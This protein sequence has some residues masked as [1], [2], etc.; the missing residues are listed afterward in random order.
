[1]VLR[2]VARNALDPRLLPEMAR[3]TMRRVTGRGHARQ[4]EAAKE[5][6]HQQSM[7]L[8]DLTTSLDPG[9]WTETLAWSESFRI[10]AVKKLDRLEVNLGGGGHYPLMYFLTRY[11]QPISVVE[12]GV[13]AGWTSSAI[14]SALCNNG[15]GHLWSSDLP[16][17]RLNRPEQYVG[18]L[19]EPDL[20]S[21]WSL[22]TDGDRTALPR[23]AKE[24]EQIDLFHYDSDKTYE[25]RV[26]AYD[27][28][29]SL[30]PASGI[31]IWDDIQDNLHFRDLSARTDQ[32]YR[33]LEFEGKY[34][35]LIGSLPRNSSESA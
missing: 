28:L 21:R 24:I 17:F 22:S 8:E 15:A 14:L 34:V 6:A 18:V 13:A 9:L 30:F 33:V 7:P 11:L 26:F 5:W 20:R 32:P 19:V 16:Y 10:S 31:L 23:F 29:R 35:G 27:L 1:M 2:A 3:K 4:S 12:T 25:G